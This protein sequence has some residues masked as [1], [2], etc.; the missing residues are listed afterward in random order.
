MFADRHMSHHRWFALLLLCLMALGLVPGL[1]WA[2]AEQ[3][4][5][6]CFFVEADPGFERDDAWVFTQTAS[7]GFFDPGQAYQGQRAAFVGIPDG[8]ENQEVDSTVWQR[9]Q[10]PVADQITM[11]AYWRSQEGDGEDARYIVLW[12]LATDESSI[13]VYEQVLQEAWTPITVDL[14][15]FAGKEVLLVFGIHNDGQGKKAG[16]WVD[17]VRVLACGLQPPTPASVGGTEVAQRASP[18]ASPSPSPTPPPTAQP[19]FTP[20]PTPTMS[21]TPTFLPTA[22]FTPTPHPTTTPTV[23]PPSPT[24][25]TTRLA[26]G[27]PSR[28]GLP[29]NSAL[30]LLTAVALSGGFALLVVV[31]SL[32]R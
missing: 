16:M 18:T 4:P 7:P 15:P 11:T 6:G 20:T 26:S 27:P 5:A 12:D 17:E 14:T 24:P 32:R 13:L 1:V 2:Q 21:P 10:L 25:A 31:I 23:P 8:S 22:T 19:S 29:D 30:P 3:P 9:M 28:S